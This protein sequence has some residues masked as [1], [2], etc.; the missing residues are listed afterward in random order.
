MIAQLL[1][2]RLWIAIA[3]RPLEMSLVSGCLTER[4]GGEKYPSEGCVELHFLPSIMVQVVRELLH[5]T[6]N[7]KIVGFKFIYIQIEREKGLGFVHAM[8]N[9]SPASLVFFLL[10]LWRTSLVITRR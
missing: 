3:Y 10:L 7:E 2:H 6:M 8:I 4:G 9:V 1:E 5:R